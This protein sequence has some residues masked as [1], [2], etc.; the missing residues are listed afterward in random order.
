MAHLQV[1]QDNLDLCNPA[2]NLTVTV[3][4]DKIPVVLLA[5][6]D[7]CDDWTKIKIA[8]TKIH[9]HNLVEFLILYDIDDDEVLMERKLR[10]PT[11][12]LPQITFSDFDDGLNMGVLHVSSSTGNALLSTILH[13]SM[14]TRLSGGTRLLLD[15]E[16]SSRAERQAMLRK[17]LFWSGITFLITGCCCSFILSVRLQMLDDDDE[18]AVAP[19]RPERRRLTFD[20]V[21]EWV[22][23]YVHRCNGNEEDNLS[24]STPVECTVCLDPF[25]DGD[26]LR[27]LPCQHEFHSYCIAKWLVERNSTCPLCKLDL[28]RDDEQSS[29]EDEEDEEASIVDTADVPDLP[30]NNEQ[31]IRQSS[32]GLFWRRLWGGRHAVYGEVDVDQT[33]LLSVDESTNIELERLS[34]DSDDGDD[35]N[36]DEENGS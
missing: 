20:Q 35:H 31:N 36:D 33:P 7:A 9:P 8:K 15:G 19:R 24:T 26:Y 23:E 17:A 16:S 22:P 1:F 28:L 12:D 3:P 18:S 6:R 25:L 13:E 2:S 27:K 4:M 5:R 32:L 34:D 11:G 30:T 14:H 10:S 21:E 29:S